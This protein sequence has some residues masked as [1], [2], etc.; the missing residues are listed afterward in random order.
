MAGWPAGDWKAYFDQVAGLPA[1]ETLVFALGRFEEESNAEDAESAE[2]RAKEERESRRGGADS[3]LSHSAP[4]AA[5]AFKSLLAVDLGCGD[6]RDTVEML[7]R[8]WRV[9]AI[10]SEADGIARLEARVPAEARG[11]LTTAVAKFEEARW[12]RCELVNASF[13]IPHCSPSDFPGLWERI[14]ES[15]KPGG[16]FAGQFFG[17][18]DSWAKKPDGVTRTYHTRAEV[19]A[20]LAPFAVEMLDEVEKDGKN[21]FGEPKYWH[22]FHV[23]ARKR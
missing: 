11:R 5:S 14:V 6:G 16:R 22:V 8:G 4:S 17:V 20:L 10:D 21:A 23:V 12:P 18:N 13:S 19:D 7:R 3:A 15:I 2:R 9:H 1:R